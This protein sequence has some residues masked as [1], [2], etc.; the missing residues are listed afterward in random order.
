MTG[1]IE[2]Q[3]FNKHLNKCKKNPNR[4]VLTDG[5]NTVSVTCGHTLK[6]ALEIRVESGQ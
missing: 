6:D 3:N 1:F 2:A 4:I 5:K